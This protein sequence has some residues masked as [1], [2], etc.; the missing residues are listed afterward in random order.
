M[1]DHVSLGGGTHSRNTSSKVYDVTETEL[2]YNNLIEFSVEMIPTSLVPVGVTQLFCGLRNLPGDRP[3]R[4][5]AVQF[6]GVKCSCCFGT[7][8][9][10]RV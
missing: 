8:E 2:G 9:D 6:N 1:I 3:I 4:D 10:R 7:M 5:I